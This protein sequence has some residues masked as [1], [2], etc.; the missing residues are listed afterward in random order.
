VA[1]PNPNARASE[2]RVRLAAPD[3]ALEITVT[4]DGCGVGSSVAGVGLTSMRRRAET[5]G[6][7]SASRPRPR[8]P[9]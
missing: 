5:L 9:P 1:L 4:D 6:G 8:A 2:V 7:G 3:S